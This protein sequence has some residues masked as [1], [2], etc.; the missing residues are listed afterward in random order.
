M[1]SVVRLLSRE[2]I[3]LV[4]WAN[5]VAWPVAYFVMTKWL[6]NFAFRTDINIATFLFSGLAAVIIAILTIT[7]QSIKAALSYPVDSLRYE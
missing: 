6:K 5:I 4:I 7:F 3:V 2:F 1:G